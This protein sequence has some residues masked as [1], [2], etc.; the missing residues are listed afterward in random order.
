MVALIAGR[1]R[2][3]RSCLGVC[4]WRVRWV[5]DQ[6]ARIMERN[7]DAVLYSSDVTDRDVV[8][9]HNQIAT[10]LAMAC[11]R[12]TSLRQHQY[13]LAQWHHSEAEVDNEVEDREVVHEVDREGAH[14]GAH[15]EG[16]EVASAEAVVG[17]EVGR[18]EVQ[19]V[20]VGAQG[21]P[22]NWRAVVSGREAVTR[23]STVSE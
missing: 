10:F 6:D 23:N 9:L 14:V 12:A 3:A 2:S 19:E 11:D 21:I 4:I 17:R 7:V 22:A 20:E 16:H 13:I 5:Q 18:E 1:G 15:V 8:G